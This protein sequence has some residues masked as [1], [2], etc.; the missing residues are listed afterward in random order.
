MS[1]ALTARYAILGAGIAGIAAAEAIREVDP[2]GEIL[3]VKP[4]DRR[5]MG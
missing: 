5:L 1:Q 2:A 4:P 3:L